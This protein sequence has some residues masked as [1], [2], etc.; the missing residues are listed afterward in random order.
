[1]DLFDQ[2]RA[3]DAFLPDLA[4]SLRALIVEWL[5]IR[6]RRN[7]ISMMAAIRIKNVRK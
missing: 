7:R 3:A 2:D 6:W 4:N 5:S 1:M